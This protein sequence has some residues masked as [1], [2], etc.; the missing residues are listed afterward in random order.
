MIVKE[1]QADAE[2]IEVTE[3]MIE[4]GCRELL[5]GGRL[6]T[7]YLVSSDPLLVQRIFRAMWD[8]RPRSA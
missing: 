5:D 1:G 6:T 8:C 7:D 4:A 3:E 2:S